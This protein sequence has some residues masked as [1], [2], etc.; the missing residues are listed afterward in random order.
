MANKKISADIKAKTNINNKILIWAIIAI[1]LLLVLIFVFKGIGQN[2]AGGDKTSEGDIE[3]LNVG[4]N[5]DLSVDDFDSL[6][7]SQ[8][9]IST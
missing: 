9:E 1:I 4:D 3:S 2:G 6:Q 8:E 7:V 5:P